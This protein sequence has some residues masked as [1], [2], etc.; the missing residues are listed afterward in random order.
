[1]KKI[2]PCLWCDNTVEQMAEFYATIFRTDFELLETRRHAGGGPVPAGAILSMTFRIHD[3]E[4]MA[5]NGGPYYKM[6]PGISFFV[7]CDDQAEVDHYWDSLIAGGEANR[8]GWLTDKFGVTWQIVPGILGELT[9]DPD[10]ARSV[11]TTM[12]MLK[13]GKLDVAALQHAHDNPGSLPEG[14]LT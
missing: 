5:I 1:M 6:T 14:D 8:C 4:F 11:A 10:Q 7:L 9:Q 13:M 3:Q 2:T 12:A